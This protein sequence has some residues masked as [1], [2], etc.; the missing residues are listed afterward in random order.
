M[1][2]TKLDSKKMEMIAEHLKSEM[3]G[4][5]FALIA[6][7][8]EN[9]SSIGTYISNVNDKYMVKAMEYQLNELKKKSSIDT[10][11]GDQISK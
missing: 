2:C 8:I 1:D 4:C 9:G 5:G 7:E 6:F 3:P 10:A 11:G